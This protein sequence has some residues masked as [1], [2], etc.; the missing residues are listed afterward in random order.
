MKE[1]P[2]CK[3]QYTDD[4]LQFCLQDGT[5][6]SPAASYFPGSQEESETVVS[7]RESRDSSSSKM[8]FLLLIAAVAALVVLGIGALGIWY[9]LNT[10][11]ANSN[12][13]N[14]NAINSLPTA[15]QT[16]VPSPTRTPPVN[17]TPNSNSSPPFDK[18]ELENEV[19]DT[20]DDWVSNTESLNSGT[21]MQHY[22]ERVDYYNKPGANHDAVQRD[23]ERAFAKFDEI[24]I[25]IH[26]V[27]ITIDGSGNNATAEFD[28]TWF[29]EGDTVS[30]G[31][32]RSQLKFRL[33]N[34]RWLITAERDLKVY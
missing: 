5:P 19:S 15:T 31:K 3:T 29:F 1:C 34:R 22:A 11:P 24:D 8:V 14:G 33:V 30:K 18:K 13:R 2:A 4:T 9:V 32:V 12:Q 28:K 7:R 10:E 26:N 27:Q 21:L 23:K 16:P 6:L 17:I 20:L 25:D